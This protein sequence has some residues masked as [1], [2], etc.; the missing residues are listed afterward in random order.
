MDWLKRQQKNRQR[1]FIPERNLEAKPFLRRKNTEH[2]GDFFVC[3]STRKEIGHHEMSRIWRLTQNF[4]MSHRSSQKKKLKKQKLS[5]FT[6]WN[7]KGELYYEKNKR[8]I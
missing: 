1:Y 7:E 3:G 4:F 8:D 6:H 2:I 5:N